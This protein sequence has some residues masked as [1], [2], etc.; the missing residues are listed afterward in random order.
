M[1]RRALGTPL[2]DPVDPADP[3]DPAPGRGLS[4]R[5]FLGAVT[6]ASG[7]VVVTTVGQ[8]VAP[9]QDLAVLAPRRPDVG[10][11]G[12]PV[13][14]SAAA[15]RVL[16]TAVDPAYR[17]LVAGGDTALRLS[18]ADLEALPQVTARL[19]I[20]CVE[21]WSASAHWTGVRVRD[22]L[23]TAGVPTGPT[24]TSTPCRSAVSTA[25]RCCPPTSGTT[26]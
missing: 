2:A 3:A 18:L 1:A 25:R 4:R 10:P 23:R 6:V 13:N 22:L 8:T 7:A 15:A 19:P 14:K 17:L 5:G 20:A 24:S 26:R 11:Q 21:G 16:T 12:L 9:L